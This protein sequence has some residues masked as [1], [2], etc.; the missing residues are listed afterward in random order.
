[1]LRRHCV[2]HI[3]VDSTGGRGASVVSEAPVIPQTKRVAAEMIEQLTGEELSG[4]LL[5]RAGDHSF[6]GIGVP[7]LF[8]NVSE[9]PA[10]AEGED[11]AF[12]SLFGASDSS[13]GRGGGL[14]WWWHTP[15]DTP[16]KVD[17]DNLVRDTGIY[18]AATWRFAT[19]AAL[20]LRYSD[21]ASWMRESLG[22]MEG[23]ASSKDLRE[24]GEQLGFL[25]GLLRQIENAADEGSV[26]HDEYNQLLLRLGHCLTPVALTGGD[27]F[28]VDPALP[29]KPIPSLDATRQ[30][31]QI[32]P[33]SEEWY[34]QRIAAARDLNR[35]NWAVSWACEMV[36]DALVRWSMQ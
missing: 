12:S 36:G 2:V 10:P 4:K 22:P 35:V 15:E 21:L 33:G 16:D 32:T 9:Q 31:L 29:Q 6:L 24:I 23:A 20:P 14:G 25:Y 28:S 1:E 19:D 18:L 34:S 27:P 13:G 11:T 7:A 17:G 30:L 8:M 5:G 26:P 3:N